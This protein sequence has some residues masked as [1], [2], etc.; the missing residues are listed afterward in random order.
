MTKVNQDDSTTAGA[1]QWQV[2]YEHRQMWW[3]LDLHNNRHCEQAWQNGFEEFF[4]THRW[5]DE[6]TSTY[7]LNF[8]RMEV[9]NQ[10]TK[11]SRP[12]RRVILE[13]DVRMES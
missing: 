12:M 2:Y 8:G 9:V 1:A 5:S 6:R 4:Y 7:V 3:D 10:G 13:P 11:H